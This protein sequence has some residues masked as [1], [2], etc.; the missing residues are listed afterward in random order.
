[1]D[2]PYAEWFWWQDV[3]WFLKYQFFDNKYSL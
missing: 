2:L 1:M 3:V